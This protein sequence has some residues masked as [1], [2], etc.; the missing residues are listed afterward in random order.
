MRIDAKEVVCKLRFWHRRH[1]PM[2]NVWSYFTCLQ[3]VTEDEKSYLYF[4]IKKKKGVDPK[5][6]QNLESI[7]VVMGLGLKSATVNQEL[8]VALIHRESETLRIKMLQ[9]LQWD[10]LQRILQRPNFIFYFQFCQIFWLNFE[11]F[12][13]KNF[14]G[15]YSE[16][17]S[18]LYC[19]LLVKRLI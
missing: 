6:T 17:F 15:A 1:A 12:F 8:N 4:N 2:K 13:T 11:Y 18:F 14:H 5:N 19:M 3:N 16:N 9:E 10:V 7:R